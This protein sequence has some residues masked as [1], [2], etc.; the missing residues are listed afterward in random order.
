MC[1][2]TKSVCSIRDSFCRVS[3]FTDAD[4][5]I[6]GDVT[7]GACCVDDYTAKALGAD[8]LVHYGHSCL[9]NHVLVFS[10]FLQEYSGSDCLCLG[11]LKR[12]DQFVAFYFYC[13]I[14][15]I[16]VSYN[17]CSV[18]TANKCFIGTELTS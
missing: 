10:A 8:L 2:G 6:M 16:S 14:M 7:Y 17:C 13:K 3:R 9:G 15:L 11:L 5:L 1:N 12:H 4:T 18:L